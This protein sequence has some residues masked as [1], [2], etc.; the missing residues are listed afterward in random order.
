MDVF[1]KKREYRVKK[2]VCFLTP[3][4]TLKIEIIIF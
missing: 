2:S 4:K 1:L 3:K